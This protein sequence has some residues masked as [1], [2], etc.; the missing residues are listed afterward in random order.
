MSFVEVSSTENF[1]ES[2]MKG[3]EANGKSILLINVV[4]KFY[5]I[6]NIC[7]HMGCKLS[8]GSLRGEIIHC[9]CHGSRF[10]AKTGQVVG[11][12]ATK[13][14]PSYEVKVEGSRI[15]VKV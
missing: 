9:A 13:S 1:A 11:G 7:T 15:L 3:V 10:E 8:S 14:E 12:P 5:A 4:D 6:G 2:S